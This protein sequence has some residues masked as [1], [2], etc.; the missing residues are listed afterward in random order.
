MLYPRTPSCSATTDDRPHRSAAAGD[1][2]AGG[3]WLTLSRSRALWQFSC[4]SLR[5]YFW[6]SGRR[7]RYSWWRFMRKSV[8]AEGSALCRYPSEI[9]P[10]LFSS[11]V[12]PFTPSFR[13]V[14]LPIYQAAL[15]YYVVDLRIQHYHRSPTAPHHAQTVTYIN[16]VAEVA[17]NHSL[18]TGMIVATSPNV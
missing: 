3:T 16:K 8:R 11:D 10:H 7:L 5:S 13:I 18:A 15:S 1:R 17:S 2:E 4:G 9:V 14:S 12:P 6:K